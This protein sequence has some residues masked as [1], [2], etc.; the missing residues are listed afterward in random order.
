M[1]RPS[2]N[3]IHKV[4]R[5]NRGLIIPE[6]KARFLHD[7]CSNPGSDCLRISGSTP[8]TWRHK[9]RPEAIIPD[10][11]IGSYEGRWKGEGTRGSGLD[12]NLSV[13]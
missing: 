3:I 10:E 8:A 6:L 11:A 4:R 2:T 9:V 5:L 13:Y 7:D 1:I 12:V